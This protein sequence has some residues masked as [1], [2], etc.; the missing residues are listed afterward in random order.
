MSRTPAIS[1]SFTRDVDVSM[2][3]PGPLP[4]A[5]FTL[6]TPIIRR[7]AVVAG[8]SFTNTRELIDSFF[9]I[10]RKFLTAFHDGDGE[11][12]TETDGETTMSLDCG[13]LSASG[14]NSRGACGVGTDEPWVD[15]HRPIILPRVELVRGGHGRWV[16]QTVSGTFAW[17]WNV[18]N[19]LGIASCNDEVVRSP[20]RVAIDDKVHDVSFAE[21][22][23]F[24]RQKTDNTW[25]FC[26][27]QFLSQSSDDSDNGAPTSIG[28]SG[29]V[30]HWTHFDDCSFGFTP[31][32]LRAFGRNSYGQ[33]G[34]GWVDDALD[35][36]EPVILPD[37]V[38]AT[39]VVSDGNSTFLLAHHRCFA[40]GRNNSGQL[41]IGSTDDTYTPAELRVLVDQII[42]ASD[43]TIIRSGSDLMACGDNSTH[44]IA[45]DSRS[46]ISYPMPLTMPAIHGVE[47]PFTK[48][49][50]MNDTTLFLLSSN[51]KW[52][53]RGADP[54]SFFDRDGGSF[55]DDVSS[56]TL[57]TES[58][59]TELSNDD[60]VRFMMVLSVPVGSRL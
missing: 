40:C 26:P 54:H 39:D 25:L 31:D 57:V 58:H 10:C 42:T 13:W 22:K 34:V 37:G 32:E 7:I 38:I 49:V 51:G 5:L 14:D 33:C 30:T 46:V 23:T 9:M 43:V 21:H 35:Y 4:N 2:D 45:S 17:G 8:L 27:G 15:R 52:V 18:Y 6:T 1:S 56:W 50:L 19:C 55:D 47:G 60:N 53:G 3:I 24:F 36:L 20:M 28:N 29:S 44:V 16:A 41:G 11:I 59:A 12:M 48:V